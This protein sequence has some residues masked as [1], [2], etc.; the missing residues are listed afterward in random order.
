MKGKVFAMKNKIKALGLVCGTL[1]M[2]GI[3]VLGNVFNAEAKDFNCSEI[4]MPPC[5]YNLPMS[6]DKSDKAYNYQIEDTIDKQQK[7]Y[8]HITKYSY[9]GNK[10]KNTQNIACYD[11]WVEY[12]KKV[13]HSN[14]TVVASKAKEKGRLRFTIYNKKGKQISSFIDTFTKKDGYTY[15][16]SIRD[17]LI[18]GNMLYYV[19]LKDYEHAHI[20][21]V[22][23]KSGKL[24]H[25]ILLKNKAKNNIEKMEIFNN[26]IYVLTENAVN[27]YSFAGKKQTSYTLPKGDSHYST[28]GGY[29]FY[30]YY[31]NMSVSGKYIYFVNNDGVYRCSIKNKQ[32]FKLYYDAKDDTNFQQCKVFD[33]CAAG[34]DRFYIMFIEKDNIDMNMPTK[35]VEYAE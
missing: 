14:Q 12:V 1:F 35:L 8:M 34:K 21:C 6:L 22:D 10:A 11:E 15:N 31:D 28:S 23:T 3:C 17:M 32:G 7:D 13:E 33:I 4:Q 24:K 25:D 2:M 26:R 20:R 30:S 9:N 19:Y 5:E 29:T 16:M 18:K 27:I